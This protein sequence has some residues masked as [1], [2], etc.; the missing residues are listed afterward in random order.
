VWITSG[1]S[2][3]FADPTRYDEFTADEHPTEE[4]G[5]HP[6]LPSYAVL[7]RE[8]AVLAKHNRR[9]AIGPWRESIVLPSAVTVAF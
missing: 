8:H 9:W 7:A 2:P 4:L 3:R 6:A 5:A 1:V